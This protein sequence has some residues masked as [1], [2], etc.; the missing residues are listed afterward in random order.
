[1]PDR[2]KYSTS[3]A[4]VEVRHFTTLTAC[5]CPDRLY[6]RRECKHMARLAAAHALIAAQEAYN[7]ERRPH[8]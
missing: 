1:M 7:K 6:R 3:P 5:S 4:P 8:D 2:S